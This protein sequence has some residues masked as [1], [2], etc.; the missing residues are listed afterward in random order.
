MKLL[1][2]IAKSLGLNGIRKFED[3]EGLASA[4]VSLRGTHDLLSRQDSSAVAAGGTATSAEAATA[5][6]TEATGSVPSSGLTK[7][8]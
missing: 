3:K 5:G 8:T 2:T 7:Q 6:S 4:I 1:R